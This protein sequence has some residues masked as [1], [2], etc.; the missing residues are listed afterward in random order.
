[1]KV[2]ADSGPRFVVQLA[3]DFAVVCWLVLW[4]W[5][6]TVV[7]DGIEVLADPGERISAAA[8]D[9]SGSLA[10]AGGVLD[11][12]PVVGD[13]VSAPFDKAA[14]ASSAMGDAGDS[15]AEAVRRLAFWAGVVVALLPILYV[16]RRYLP[17][18]VR[19]LLDATAADRVLARGPDG[20]DLELFAWR[21]VTTL[22]LHRVVRVSD[23]PVGAIRRGDADVVRRLAELEL[24]RIGVRPGATDR[25]PGSLV[26]GDV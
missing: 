4:V 3:A 18:R 10:D 5:L 11:G 22:P 12:T 19:F 16:L 26:G 23:D 2:Y 1:M 7:H 13:E 24:S 25:P 14:E 15:T 17:W 9:L 21:A 8:E 6:G 20:G